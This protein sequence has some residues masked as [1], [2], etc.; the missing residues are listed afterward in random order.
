MAGFSIVNLKD[1]ED[2]AGERSPDIEAHIARKHIDSDHLGVSYFRYAPGYRNSTGHS[3][4]EQEEI[5]VVVSGSGSIKLDDQVLP[6]RQWPALLDWIARFTASCSRSAPTVPR[7]A[8]VQPS[9]TGGPRS[10][11]RVRE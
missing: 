3:H 1:I 11:Q 8:T 9:P 4:R 7:A 6:L 10:R 5:Y 2:S